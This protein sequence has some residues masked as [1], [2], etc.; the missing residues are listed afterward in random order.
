MASYCIPNM[1]SVWSKQWGG[2]DIPQYWFWDRGAGQGQLLLL[3]HN[4]LSSSAST[5]FWCWHLRIEE[6]C[7]NLYLILGNWCTWISEHALR[8]WAHKRKAL[9]KHAWLQPMWACA[10]FPTNVCFCNAESDPLNL[11]SICALRKD[12]SRNS[13]LSSSWGA[14]KKWR[15]RTE[16]RPVCKA[17]CRSSNKPSDQSALLFLLPRWCPRRCDQEAQSSML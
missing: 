12:A 7:T 15:L 5:N 14:F 2:A 6:V 10:N 16:F 17:L 9:F 3:H 1:Y 8:L 4:C 13:L 11:S